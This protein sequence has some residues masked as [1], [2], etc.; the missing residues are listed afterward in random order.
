MPPGTLLA[1]NTYMTPEPRS[2]RSRGQLLRDA[3]VTL[4]A[5]LLAF[6]AFDDITTDTATTF[7]FEWV[8]LAVCGVC[9]LFVSWRLLRSEHRWLGS[10]SVVALAAAAGAGSTIRPGTGP[11]QIEYLITLA[12]LLWFLLLVGML[13][14]LAWRRTVRDAA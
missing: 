4:A 8:G 5:V 2:E 12:G 9:L 11:F 7:T 14:A 13:T 10:L 6:A 3:A 1:L